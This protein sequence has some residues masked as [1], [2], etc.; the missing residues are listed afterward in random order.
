MFDY[1]RLLAHLK[2]TKGKLRYK[3][4]GESQYLDKLARLLTRYKALHEDD[5]FLSGK[6]MVKELVPTIARHP[7]FATAGYWT[8]RCNL[9]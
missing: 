9:A 8:G 4:V 7:G 2:W 1:F 6:S 5:Q 3:K